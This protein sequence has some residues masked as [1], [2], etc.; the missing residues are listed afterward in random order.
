MTFTVHVDQTFVRDEI[1]FSVKSVSGTEKSWGPEPLAERRPDRWNALI[2]ALDETERP[3]IIYTMSQRETNLLAEE[4]SPHI[5]KCLA[6]HA[7]LTNERR[8]DVEAEFIEG[9]CDVIVATN[10]FGMGIDKADIRSVIHWSTPASPEALYQEA[11]RAARG[12]DVERAKAILVF[13]ESDLDH[14]YRTV[15][16]DVPVRWEIERVDRVLREMADLQNR[17]IITVTDRDLGRLALLRPGLSVRVVLAHLER[18]G[19]VNELDRHYATMSVRR[20]GNSAESLTTLE[21]ELLAAVDSN[22]EYVTLSTSALVGIGGTSR[23]RD[24]TSA[25]NALIRRG[26]LEQRRSVAVRLLEDDPDDLVELAKSASN[27]IWKQLLRHRDDHGANRYHRSLARADGDARSIRMGIEVLSAFGLVEVKYETADGAIPAARLNK[28]ANPAKLGTAYGSAHRLAAALRS[29]DLRGP[30]AVE[31]LAARTELEAEPL[32]DALGLLHLVGAA[33]VDLRSWE[34]MGSRRTTDDDAV[35]VAREIAIID[36]PD[37]QDCLANAVVASIDRA[38]LTRLRLETLRRYAAIEPG[39][40]LNDRDAYQAYLERYLT[41]PDFLDRVAADTTASLV[42]HLTPRQRKIVQEPA[43]APIVILAG[44]GTGKTLT[45]VTRIAYRVRSGY[46]LPERILAVTFTRAATAEMRARLAQFGVRGVDVRTLDSLAVKLVN[47]NWSTM[48]FPARPS[49]L[50]PAEQHQLLRRLDPT[51]NTSRELQKISLAK[52]ERRPL[53]EQLHVD[54]QGALETSNRI[55][56]QDAKAKAAEFLHRGGDSSRMYL[57]SLDEVYV[58]EYQDLSPLQI[59]LVEAISALAQ[60]TVVGDPRQAIYEW[61][62]ARPDEL[63]RLYERELKAFDLVENFR[64]TRAILD[65]A[66]AVIQAALP[67]LQPVV[68]AAGGPSRPVDQH[69][70]GSEEAMFG[71]VARTVQRWLDSGVPDSEIAVLARTNDMVSAIASWLREHHI[72]AHEEGLPHVAATHAFSILERFAGT[73]LEVDSDSEDS[74]LDQLDQLGTLEEVS[75][76]LRGRDDQETAENAS[77][78]GRLRDAVDDCERMGAGD[79]VAAIRAIKKSEDGPRDRAGVVVTTMTRSKGLEWDAVAVTNLGSD[80]MLDK[81]NQGRDLPCPLRLHHP[82]ASAPRPELG[83]PTYEVARLMSPES[84]DRPRRRTPRMVPIYLPGSAAP[85][86]EWVNEPSAP[87]SW[88]AFVN[89]TYL[90]HAWDVDVTTAESVEGWRRASAAYMDELEK[91]QSEWDEY[92][93]AVETGRLS[94]SA[95]QLE[96]HPSILD[97]FGNYEAE[98]AENKQML[99]AFAEMMLEEMKD[100]EDDVERFIEGGE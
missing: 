94:V 27:R 15:R 23:P 64:S 40:D 49:I 81:L 35:D 67:E 96:E 4:L 78:W 88:G 14:A 50:E 36:V 83:R 73:N 24:V 32:M 29:M 69:S 65:T 34:D 41:E 54:Y 5:G 6:Y 82:R 9:R 90:P 12:A 52:A 68:A 89:D 8:R 44:P 97:L 2:E 26:L 79:L 98:I 60:L 42:E 33:S 84:S 100:I 80:E 25:L 39:D 99:T 13:H 86:L 95:A 37:R 59:D 85:M 16:R 93:E 77:D 19:L 74:L 72:A 22:T 17:N 47:D 71:H 66:N 46:V 7:G 21:T 30:L 20:T 11:G 92:E 61:N 31:D 1:E 55:D 63:I 45:L 75:V 70:F 56:F 87:R 48:G 28:H 76:M 10:A 38:R 62:G 51:A 91:L 57:E 43:T 18:A 3:T 58:D 53:I